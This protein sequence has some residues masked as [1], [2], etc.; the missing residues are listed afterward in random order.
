MGLPLVEFDS[1]K[2]DTIRNI[3]WLKTVAVIGGVNE[4]SSLN[5][6]NTYPNPSSGQFTIHSPHT[7]NYGLEIYNVLGE[8]VFQKTVNRKDEPVNLNVPNGIYFLH[9]TSKEGATMRKVI[10]SK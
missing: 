10:I 3:T 9:I 1:T 5:E 8:R 4:T 6:V 7:T 2:A